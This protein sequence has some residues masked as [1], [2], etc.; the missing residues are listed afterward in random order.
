MCCLY[1]CNSNRPT[2]HTFIYFL[3]GHN[4]PT[5]KHTHKHILRKL[6]QKNRRRE[7]IIKTDTQHSRKEFFYSSITIET[8]ETRLLLYFSSGPIPSKKKKLKS[9]T[10]TQKISARIYFFNN[11]KKF[12]HNCLIHTCVFLLSFECECKYLMLISVSSD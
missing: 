11:T 5:H 3:I 4:K 9:K 2:Y 10:E 6:P 12:H 1:V 8:L 7:N